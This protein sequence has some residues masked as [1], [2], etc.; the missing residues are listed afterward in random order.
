MTKAEAPTARCPARSS[1]GHGAG[2]TTFGN[3]M[4]L[5]AVTSEGVVITTTLQC[6]LVTRNAESDTFHT[7]FQP[8]ASDADRTLFLLFF[9]QAS[10]IP[11]SIVI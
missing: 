3:H 2:P 4:K 8:G 10:W 1:G 7:R 9:G 6:S 5:A 11:K